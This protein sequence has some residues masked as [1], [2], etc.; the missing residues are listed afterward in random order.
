MST[1]S[2]VTCWAS[3]RW[4]TLLSIIPRLRRLVARSGRNASGRCRAS[5]RRM[6]T[7]SAVACRASSG[8]PNSRRQMPWLL[9]LMAKSA[10]E[11]SGRSAAS[12]RPIST[13][14]TVAWRAS[15]RSPS[16]PNIFPR[17]FR[18]WANWGRKASGRCAASRRRIIT[19]SRVAWKASS[20]S[21][22]SL[23]R[24]PTLLRSRA[25][26]QFTDSSSQQGGNCST[27]VRTAQRPT[28]RSDTVFQGTSGSSWA[29]NSAVPL[30]AKVS[31]S[32]CPSGASAVWPPRVSAASKA[33]RA[34]PGTSA[35]NNPASQTVPW[36]SS[37]K[38]ILPKT[39]KPLR[40]AASPLLAKTCCR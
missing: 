36:D 27:R 10:R 3:S 25:R 21:P 40:K 15:S 13:A 23:R 19:A 30:R 6:S 24:F 1:A 32:T 29:A 12:R 28:S 14:S 34:R 2:A 31:A 17:L 20:R 33:A 5:S 18:L 38:A 4:P 8:R 7:A 11:A 9:R 37:H 35:S 26:L 16:L 39:T 22:R